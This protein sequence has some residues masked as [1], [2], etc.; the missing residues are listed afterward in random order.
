MKDISH[1]KAGRFISLVQL[2]KYVFGFVNKD[3]R[4]DVKLSFDNG[5]RV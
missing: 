4:V 1:K 2:D 3:R 5:A